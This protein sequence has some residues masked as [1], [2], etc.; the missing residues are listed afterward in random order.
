MPAASDPYSV[1]VADYLLA[2]RRRLVW[3]A[4]IPLVVGLIAGV[5]L[6]SNPREFRSRATVTLPAGAAKNQG[7]STGE[8]A[9]A[10]ADFEEVIVSEAVVDRVARETGASPARIKNHISTRRLGSSRLINVTYS[11]TNRSRAAKVVGAA[12]RAA[13]ERLYEPAV[14]AANTA[15]AT[16]E[17]EL[18]ALQAQ[19]A[20]FPAAHGLAVSPQEAYQRKQRELAAA[21]PEQ[22]AQGQADL[23]QLASLASQLQRLQSRVGPLTVVANAAT[24]RQ[25]DAMARLEASKSPAT[26]ELL[27]T[28]RLPRL[29]PIVT[30]VGTAVGAALLLVLALIVVLEALD[31]ARRPPL[32]ALS[33]SPAN[34]PKAAAPE[35]ASPS[36]PSKSRR[37]NKR[38]RR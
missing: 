37:R 11:D 28:R 14:V 17:R 35:A 34:A 33:A 31:P 23:A 1:Q 26:V 16:S 2:I 36:S 29:K 32:T 9:Q 4:T 3:L 38:G 7:P 6:A 30:G 25:G 8:V 19:I 12:A 27:G 22:R 13:V 20:N 18:S 21:T 10:A 5:V 24:E 15:V